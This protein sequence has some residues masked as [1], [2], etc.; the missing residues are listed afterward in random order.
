[1]GGDTHGKRDMSLQIFTTLVIIAIP[2]STLA[3]LNSQFKALQNLMDPGDFGV[4]SVG[5][6]LEES[7]SDVGMPSVLEAFTICLR[8]QLKVLG[9]KGYSDRGM[10]ANIGDLYAME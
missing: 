8:F 5:A 3:Q 2:V 6:I 4:T 9:S 10:V 1:M 7:G